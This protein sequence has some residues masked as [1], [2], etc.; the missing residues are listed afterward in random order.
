MLI[1]LVVSL[2]LAFFVIFNS[3][4]SEDG[5]F[6]LVFAGFVL[7]FTLWVLSGLFPKTTNENQHG[8]GYTKSRQ[9]CVSTTKILAVVICIILPLFGFWIGMQYENG[10][11]QRE[12]APINI[13]SFEILSSQKTMKVTIN[14]N[15]SVKFEALTV[16][17]LGGGHKILQ[18]PDGGRG[19]DLSFAEI[20]L[21]ADDVD[22]VKM[23]VYTPSGVEYDPDKDTYFGAYR[24]RVMDVGWNGEPVTLLVENV[25]RELRLP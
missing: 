18:N 9:I 10:T 24:I 12:E 1:V 22:T 5:L 21:K 17:N 25:E 4:G 16:T 2:A 6:T 13:N 14:G 19:G 7:V 23:R 15:E 11:L 20:E 3:P 8:E